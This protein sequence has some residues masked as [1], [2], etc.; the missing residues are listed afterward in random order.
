MGDGVSGYDRVLIVCCNDAGDYSPGIYWHGPDGGGP[1]C[2]ESVRE[3]APSMPAP[4][5]GGAAAGLCG[6]LFKQL[7]GA[8]GLSLY[9]SPKPGSDG[10]VDWQAY[11]SWNV[12]LILVNVDRKMAECYSSPADPKAPKKLLVKK[13]TGLPIE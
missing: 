6:F 8:D 13:I 4:E 12:D 9:D 7:Q 2:M 1:A 11:C 10:V 5:V 3:A